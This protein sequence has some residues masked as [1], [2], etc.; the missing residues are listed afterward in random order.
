MSADTDSSRPPQGRINWRNLLTL[1][2]LTLLV[3]T[4]VMGAAI[5]GGWAIAGL[6]ELGT[7]IEYAFM[8]IF[9]L[10][11]LWAMVTFV[12]SAHRVEPVVT[13]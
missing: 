13:R 5:A 1:G 8:A 9:G 10:V 2:S 12:R 3:G 7:T 4:E 6:L 11:G